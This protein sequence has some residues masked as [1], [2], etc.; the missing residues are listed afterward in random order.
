MSNPYTRAK[1]RVKKKKGFYSHLTAYISVNLFMIFLMT[2]T[3]GEPLGWMIPAFGWGIGLA[4]HYVS[5][6][7]FP[8]I[9]V[10][11][12][13]WEERELEKELEKEGYDL[14][15]FRRDEE[16]ELDDLD[17]D[18]DDFDDDELDLNER[19]AERRRAERSKGEIER[20]WKDEDFI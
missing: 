15:S 4:S 6:F 3:G 13:D 5:I 7:G 16:L 2:F 1:K 9:G 8:I 19:R 17:D 14:K 20:Q 11:G 10:G 12:K 18:D